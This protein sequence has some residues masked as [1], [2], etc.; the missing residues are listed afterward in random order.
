ML[1]DGVL[2]LQER[3]L[4]NMKIDAWLKAAGNDFGNDGVVVAMCQVRV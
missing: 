2:G 1:I 3:S 4:L